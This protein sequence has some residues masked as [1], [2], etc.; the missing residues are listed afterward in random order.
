MLPSLLGDTEY[1][2]EIDDYYLRVMC[3]FFQNYSA[4]NVGLENG[5]EALRGKCVENGC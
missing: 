1:S 2:F 4:A 3:Y 5:I